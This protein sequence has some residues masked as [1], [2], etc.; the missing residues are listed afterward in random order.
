MAS[1]WYDSALLDIATGNI[2]LANDT[3]YVL[4]VTSSYT[5]SKGHAKRS[6][7]SGEVTGTGYTAGGAASACALALDTVNH[8]LTATFDPVSWA[9]STLSGV[10]GAVVY[11]SR[12][13]AASADELLGFVDDGGSFTSTNGTFTQTF[14]TPFLIQN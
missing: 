8:R 1:I 12:G 9:S 6:D 13:G 4:L 11:K 2:D 5:P 14:S 7:I 3:F 10:V